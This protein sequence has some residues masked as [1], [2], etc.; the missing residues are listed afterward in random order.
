MQICQNFTDNKNDPTQWVYTK[1]RIETQFQTK[2]NRR[3][4][5]R[6]YCLVWFCT[7]GYSLLASCGTLGR[8]SRN[9]W[10]PRNPGWK[11]LMYCFDS[12]TIHLKANRKKTVFHSQHLF[13]LLHL[14]YTNWTTPSLHTCTDMA[15]FV[16]NTKHNWSHFTNNATLNN[17]CV[18]TPIQNQIL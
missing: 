1:R 5:L 8:R 14:K 18:M 2:K 15:S 16:A 4:V 10:V 9:P 17:C 11:T 3:W 6:R 12:F 7:L 13:H